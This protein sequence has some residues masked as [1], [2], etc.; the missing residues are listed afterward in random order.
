MRNGLLLGKFMPFHNG[1]IA[2]ADFALANT[3]EL[4]I[5][6]CA[7]KNEIIDGSIRYNW[8]KDYYQHN[9]KV[10]VHL[11]EYDDALLSADSVSSKAAAQKWAD[12]LKEKFPGTNVFISSEPYGGYVAGYWGIDHICFDEKRQLVP[13]SATEIRLNPFKYW[14]YIPA[15]VRPY[16]IKKI[17][18]AGTE[19]TGKSVLTERLASYYKTVF[20]PEAARD[21]VSATAACTKDDL[22][23]IAAAHAS[24]IIEK[25]P[26]A[27]QLLFADTDITITKSYAAFLFGTT[28]VTEDW[29]NEANRFDLYLFL[30]TDCS[31]IQDGTRLDEESREKLN[32]SHKKEFVRQRIYYHIIKGNWEERFHSAIK[33]IDKKFFEAEI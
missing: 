24:A 13:V 1:H 31:Y 15:G 33:I 5:L 8:V 7:H 28:I 19:S 29:V 9:S 32:A 25:I 27:N 3:D 6:V 16:F 22:Y 14:S 30:E 26:L 23:T 11:I 18:I 21:I 2:L 10:H 17:C 12:Y 20:V 4:L